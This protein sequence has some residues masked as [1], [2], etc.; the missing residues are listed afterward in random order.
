MI[1]AADGLRAWLDGEDSPEATAA[2]VGI[3]TVV[4]LIRRTL[5]DG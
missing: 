5:S 3:A 1:A 2:G 4:E